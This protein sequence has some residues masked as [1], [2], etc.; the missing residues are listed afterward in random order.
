M[1][2]IFNFFFRLFLAFL[3]AKLLTGL[4]GL[5]SREA[6]LGLTGLFLANIFLFDYLNYRSRSSWRRPSSWHVPP[7]W[8]RLWK[9]REPPASE[10]SAPEEIS[11]E[12]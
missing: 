6:L 2:Y 10:P 12:S 7:F 4:F 8:R 9:R 5:P 3:V 1:K 11:P